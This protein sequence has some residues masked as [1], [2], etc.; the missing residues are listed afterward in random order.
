MKLCMFAVGKVLCFSDFL[1]G[2][3]CKN[4]VN[5]NEVAL[6]FSSVKYSRISNLVCN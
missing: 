3:F 4:N 5:G 1:W 2:V 6:G